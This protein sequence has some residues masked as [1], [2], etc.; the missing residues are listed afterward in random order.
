MRIFLKILKILG[1][2]LLVVKA[3]FLIATF[4]IY[5]FNLDGRLI[6]IAYDDMQEEFDDMERDMMI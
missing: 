5:M 1:I 2:T 6:D 4:I 3:V